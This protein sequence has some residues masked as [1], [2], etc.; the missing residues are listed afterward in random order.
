MHEESSHILYR[1]TENSSSVI[2]AA[3][4]VLTE[5]SE[6]MSCDST[7]FFQIGPILLKF[8]LCQC[9]YLSP[10]CKHTILK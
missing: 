10:S 4:Y 3:T 9:L 2:W 7:I 1:A 5:G 8:Q 6:D